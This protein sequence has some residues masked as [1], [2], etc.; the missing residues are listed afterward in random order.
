M[1]AYLHRANWKR[2]R[3]GLKQIGAPTTAAELDV[4]DEDLV[5]AFE[6]AASVRPER[7]TIFHKLR[8]TREACEKTAKMTGVIG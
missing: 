8:L 7:Y 4:S 5:K 3:D 2:I 6:L 1:S